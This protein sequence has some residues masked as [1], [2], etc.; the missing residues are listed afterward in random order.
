MHPS[1]STL[2]GM[3]GLGCHASPVVARASQGSQVVPRLRDLPFLPLSPL[4][5]LAPI[6][7]PSLSTS[8][9]TP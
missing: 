1:R 2:P 8:S 3:P 9:T 5:I 4:T 7:A 6:P